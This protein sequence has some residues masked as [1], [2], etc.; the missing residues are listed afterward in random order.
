MKT[1]LSSAGVA[2]LA[3]AAV[4]VEEAQSAPA[5]DLV[6]RLPGWD[7]ELPSRHWSGY[8][9]IEGGKH[10]HY[11]FIEKH[12]GGEGAPTV[13]WQ[14]GGP[15]CSSL[16]GLFY[17]HGPFRINATNP[18]QLIPFEFAWSRLAN[19]L[20]LE[21]PVGVGFSYS[22]HHEDYVVDDDSNAIDNLKA[23]QKFW[24]LFP[25][26]ADA[27]FFLTGESYSG[28]YTPTLAE[29]IMNA[30]R[31]GEYHGA[32]L[33][34]IAVGNGCTGTEIGT[35]GTPGQKEKFLSK[36]LRQTAI[37]SP[38]IKD[39]VAA[40]CGDFSEQMPSPHGSCLEALTEM[41]GAI[42]NVNLYDVYG[43]CHNSSSVA[44]KAPSGG[45]T[46]TTEALRGSLEVSGGDMES[47]TP[48]T[49]SL[50]ASLGLA[51][52]P[53][54]CIDSRFASFYLT[55]DEVVK[56]LHVKKPPFVWGVCTNQLTKYTPTRPNLPRDTYPDLVEYLD[57]TIIYNGDW[58]AC[59]P[60]TDNYDWTSN[61]GFKVVEDWHP[62][63]YIAKDGLGHQVAGYSV[64][65][66][67]PKNQKKFTFTTIRGGR[68]E[69]PET[70]P[71]QAFELIKRLIGDEIF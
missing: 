39:R 67:T 16:D 37:I 5:G 4:S 45:L 55:Q 14:N 58:D 13:L 71:E 1:W 32:P 70:A 56:A 33:R 41:H 64:R 25:E 52:G 19:M 21:A 9:D 20:Y 3:C 62:W 59:V 31:A 61:M 44:F 65:Y 15:G 17:E 6:D 34:G 42:G 51:P 8:L 53:A 36:F 47:N 49:N 69:V 12:G 24:T 43:E 50:G 10:L 18:S 60:W 54:A 48:G 57:R 27:D 22:D 2:V 38:K 30:D 35:C 29:A 68:H 11:Y 66:E 28:I 7:A 46:S 26:F 40:E 63:A 23:V